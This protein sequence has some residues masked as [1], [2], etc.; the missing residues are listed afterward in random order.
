MLD[1]T[2]G[3]PI[4]ALAPR[5]AG[6]VDK[7]EEWNE[8]EQL[9]QQE[10]AIE[11]PEYGPYEYEGA[12][13]FS[14][15]SDYE[16]TLQLLSIAILLRDQCSVRR[17]IH[18]LRSH[19]G[20]DGLFEQLIGAYIEDGQDLDTCIIGKP[21]STLLQVFYEDDEK[22]TL[23]LLQKYL[24]QWYPAM[25][26][27]PRWHDEHLHISEEGYAAYYGYWAFE[28]GATVFMLDLDNSQIE[29]LVYPKDLVDYARQLWKEGRHSSVEMKP[30]A[31]REPGE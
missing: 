28:A 21:Y 13:Q 31:E 2:A 10:A 24:K 5:I 20:R 11:L 22:T 18:V 15:L 3:E 30:S 12:P 4:E 7:F 14:I 1:Y 8:V 17:I 25:K 27:H 6:I 23:K 29:H 9:Y 16:D 26:N 19:R